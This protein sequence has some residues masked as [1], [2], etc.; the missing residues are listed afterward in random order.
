MS[1]P[2][3]VNSRNL[4]LMVFCAAVPLFAQR[5]PAGSENLQWLRADDS[6]LQWTNVAD[7]ESRTE[8]LQ[9]VRVPKAWRDKWP[10]RT[11]TRALATPSV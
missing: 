4:A 11:A 7:W 3:K 10:E 6:R 1:F 5:A 9:P 2:S 8:G